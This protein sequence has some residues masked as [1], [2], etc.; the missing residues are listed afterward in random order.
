MMMMMMMMEIMMITMIVRTRRGVREVDRY[1]MIMSD[2]DY[3]DHVS[4]DHVD[5]HGDAPLDNFDDHDNDRN[6]GRGGV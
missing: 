3:F 5:H 1:I 4:V 6:V 2:H